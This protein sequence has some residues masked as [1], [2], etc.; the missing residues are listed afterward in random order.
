MP[1]V[2][3]ADSAVVARHAADMGLISA[4]DAADV[5]RATMAEAEL[6]G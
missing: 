6:R 4:P 2:L 3:A 1:F 5:Q